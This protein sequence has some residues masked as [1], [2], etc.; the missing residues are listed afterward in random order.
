[1]YPLWIIIALH[2]LFWW[3]PNK[4]KT[5]FHYWAENVPLPLELFAPLENYQKT[6]FK[7]ETLIAKRYDIIFYASAVIIYH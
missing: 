2:D 3:K 7:L 1:M 5:M 4:D 6:Y